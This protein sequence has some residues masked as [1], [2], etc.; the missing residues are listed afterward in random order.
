[1]PAD[2]SYRVTRLH[3][4]VFATGRRWSQGYDTLVRGFLDGFGGEVLTGK[5]ASVVLRG[6]EPMSGIEPPTY[7]L[8]NRCST[9]EL[10]W[11]EADLGKIWVFART[12]RKK[13][14]SNLRF[15]GFAGR[16]CMPVAEQ[17]AASDPG[18]Q[19]CLVQSRE[20][21]NRRRLSAFRN[22]TGRGNF[23]GDV[24]TVLPGSVWPDPPR[25]PRWGGA[26]FGL[27]K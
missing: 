8:R 6:M 18:I 11:R 5:I 21:S 7:G 9:T 3:R 22:D 14:I 23:R 2:S 17:P 13:Y 20:S 4:P 10:H 12:G 16:R 24:A 27:L 25:S 19:S 15:A 1:M 26:K